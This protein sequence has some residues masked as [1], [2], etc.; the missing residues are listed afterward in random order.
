[1]NSFGI[2]LELKVKMLNV[3]K[4]EL[5]SAWNYFDLISHFPRIYLIT[6]GEGYIYPNNQE[7]KLEPGFLYLIPSNIP[8]TYTCSESL[9]QYYL[10]FTVEMTEQLN[11]FDIYPY[12]FK[13]LAGE[14]D[15][16]LFERLIEINP[17]A[18]LRVADPAVYQVKNWINSNADN[19]S[20]SQHIET[21]G[22]IL[23]LFSRF[24]E[25]NTPANSFTTNPMNRFR[26]TMDF[27]RNNIEKEISINELATR[28]KMSNDHFTRSF[29]KET[30]TTPLDYIN[31]K[32]IEKAQL[33]LVVTNL[34][35]NEI[36]T[37]TGFNSASYFIRSFK[38][39]TGLTPL[40]YRKFHHV[41]HAKF[42]SNDP[43][44]HPEE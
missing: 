41:L 16:R 17:D 22:L 35:I 23:Q 2:P 1:M 34:S 36:L 7:I 25:S 28:T 12:H 29:K 4:C 14:N 10:H 24:L 44:K 9:S 43:K 31:R 20:I 33:L 38:T 11:I 39:T 19:S 18:A 21:N 5:D 3:A 32:R 30:G 27:I 40:E 37:K 6:S 13:T 8:C 42:Y 15:I 26:E